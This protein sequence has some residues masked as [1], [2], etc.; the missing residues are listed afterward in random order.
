MKLLSLLVPF[1]SLAPCAWAEFRVDRIV[2]AGSEI[3][4]T[5]LNDSPVTERPTRVDL[6][7][8]ENGDGVWRT[9]K[10]WRGDFAM[11]PGSKLSF[12]YLPIRGES[13]DSALRLTRYDLQATVTGVEDATTTFEYDHNS[14]VPAEV[15]P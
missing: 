14:P 10:V 12:G 3:R 11:A 13:V 4:I 1:L 9:I 8:R 2:V 5:L 15:R 7:T 6:K